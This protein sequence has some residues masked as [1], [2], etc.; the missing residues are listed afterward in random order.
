MSAGA[1]V[2]HLRPGMP[3]KYF[4]MPLLQDMSSTRVMCDGRRRACLRSRIPLA[5]TRLVSG[6][7]SIV[8]LLGFLGWQLAAGAGLL[9]G[10][11]L[12]VDVET[13][14]VTLQMPEGHATLFPAAAADVLKDVKIGD[15]VSIELNREGKIIKLFKLPLDPGN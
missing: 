5:V 12:A 6:I 14:E 1:D 11:V 2:I 4:V 7:G 10:I 15:R 3:G 8:L 9:G 13:R